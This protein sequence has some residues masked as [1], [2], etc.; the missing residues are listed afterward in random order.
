M[1]LRFDA[2]SRRGR[3][4]FYGRDKFGPRADFADTRFDTHTHTCARASR[5]HD[6]GRRDTMGRLSILFDTL[7]KLSL[8]AS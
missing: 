6:G 2:D 3:R 5:V 4:A 8:R 1:N 7:L